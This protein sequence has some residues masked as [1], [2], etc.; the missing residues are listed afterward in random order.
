MV[1]VISEDDDTLMTPKSLDRVHSEITPVIP[2]CHR[3]PVVEVKVLL[4]V[5]EMAGEPTNVL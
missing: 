4:R 2:R 1:R 5:R 3:E